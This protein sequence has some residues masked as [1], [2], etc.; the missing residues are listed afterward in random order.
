MSLIPGICLCGAPGIH[1]SGSAFVLYSLY[2]S[3]FADS[4]VHRPPG[5]IFRREVAGG[6]DRPTGRPSASVRSQYPVA[7]IEFFLSAPMIGE[8]L[9]SP[10]S[11]RR[12]TG[13]MASSEAIGGGAGV[14]HRR[15]HGQYMIVNRE[16]AQRLVSPTAGAIKFPKTSN[17]D[18]IEQWTGYI[19]ELRGNGSDL[20][21]RLQQMMA[22]TRGSM[23]Q[24]VVA[25]LHFPRP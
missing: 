5:E 2:E 10:T 14:A 15:G 1:M 19:D 20:Q 25:V 7:S 4:S 13:Y 11:L 18:F 8:F 21:A 23:N 6:M 17:E 16:L 22:I 12:C 3:G 24:A 9:A